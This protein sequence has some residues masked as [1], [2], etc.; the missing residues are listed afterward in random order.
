MSNC[1]LQPHPCHIF[2]VWKPVFEEVHTKIFALSSTQSL[3][4]NFLK[5]CIGMK[6]RKKLL[7]WQF[8][9]KKEY[10]NRISPQIWDAH[11]SEITKYYMGS[12]LEETRAWIKKE[13]GLDVS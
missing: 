10:R 13:F 11:R 5:S 2:G 8:N 6:S 1:Y 3:V 12:T 7:Q 9:V 4:K